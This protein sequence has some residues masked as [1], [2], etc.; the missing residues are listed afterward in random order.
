[1]NSIDQL[2]RVPGDH[3]LLVGWNAP[4]RDSRSGCADA[5]ATRSVRDRIEL[6]TQ[7]GRITTDLF[8]DGGSVFANAAGEYNRIQSFERRYKRTDLASNS[9]AIEVN[10]QL[11]AWIARGQERTHVA[12][13][14]RHA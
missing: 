8:A 2:A 14:A 7:P 4:R 13:D 3:Q 11:R 5:R 1:M 10:R 9:I 12:G 6:H